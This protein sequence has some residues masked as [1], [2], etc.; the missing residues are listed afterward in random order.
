MCCLLF[1]FAFRLLR[2]LSLKSIL[3]VVKKERDKYTTF[4]RACQPVKSR[5]FLPVKTRGCNT[6]KSPVSRSFFSVITMVS[7]FDFEM[8]TCFFP[9]QLVFLKWIKCWSFI[10]LEGCCFEIVKKILQSFCYLFFHLK[11]KNVCAIKD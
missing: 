4:R 7:I 5:F 2:I 11:K 10:S 3:R 9:F 8:E 1:Y 6:A